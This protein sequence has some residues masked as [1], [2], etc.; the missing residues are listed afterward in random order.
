MS[1][2]ETYTE[3]IRSRGNEGLAQSIEKT[4]REVGDKYLSNFDYVSHRIGLLLGNIQ[5][6]KTAQMFGII[7]EAADQGFAVF[8]LLTTDNVTLQQQ[9]LE[10]VQ[11]DLNGFCI[12]GENDSMKFTKN[13]L[14]LPTLI[15]LKKNYRVLR[16]WSNVL[17]S[18]SF[19]T[20]N[21]LFILDD[22]AD[23]SSLNTLVN[24]HRQSS[25]NK[26]L[27]EIKNQA[28]SS[29]YLQVTG[30]PQAILLQNKIC[31][32][33][34]EFTY[35][36]KPGAGYLGGNFFFSEPQ[37]PCIRIIDNKKDPLREALMHHLVT[38]A[39]ML[40]SGAKTT[41]FMLHPSARKSAHS[42]YEAQVK[43]IL[44]DIRENISAESVKDDLK[45]AYCTL[46]P[47]KSKLLSLPEIYDG[48]KQLLQGDKIKI[49]I[50][51]SDNDVEAA[52]Y[53]EGS[54]IIIGGNTLGRGV[55]FGSL[56]TIYYTRTAKKP[57]ADTMWQH[58]RMFGYD[59]DPGMIQVYMDSRL[60][61]LFKD[62]NA[63]NNAIVAQVEHGLEHV[64]IYYP[65]G[66]NPTRKNVLDKENV[67]ALSGGTN[68]FPAEPENNTIAEIDELLK[69][70]DDKQKYYQSSLK[71]ILQVME[72]IETE[73]S[74]PWESFKSFIKMFLSEKP[75]AQGVLIVRRDRDIRKGSGALLSPDDWNLNNSITD[76]LVLT[77]YKMTGNK[78]WDGQKV[79]VPN[80]KLPNDVTYYA[81]D[82]DSEA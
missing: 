17:K 60:Y 53:A 59:R 1:Y 7:S 45:Q 4:A 77:L 37:N 71:F 40:L 25:I 20:G 33:H 2:L 39:Q 6:G 74:F 75:T 42:K 56:Q 22:E 21:P 19:M 18:T 28:S 36:F 67:Y 26:Y 10:R 48:V 58:S 61:K 49:M 14:E 23:A 41:N 38:S 65:E 79:W 68:Y 69:P 34:P 9:T 16:L 29:I 63:T 24:S 44:M 13:A 55:T 52:Q 76:K 32:W 27:D 47:Q 46:F 3:T 54:N 66:L 35:Y 15:V 82:E 81:V 57:Q 80:I 72:K 73:E 70:F 30:T 12:C 11:K 62:I 43:K 31:G 64:K 78:G 8:L 5:S 50:L 51:N